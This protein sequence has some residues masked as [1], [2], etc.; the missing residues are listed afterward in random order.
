MLIQNLISLK[1]NPD[2]AREVI[3][4]LNNLKYED[5]EKIKITP[6]CLDYD[7]IK[8]LISKVKDKKELGKVALFFWY[9]YE[10]R[11]QVGDVEEHKR[12]VTKMIDDLLSAIETM[13][14]Q[15]G[16]RIEKSTFEVELLS[17]ATAMLM[18]EGKSNR[19]NYKDINVDNLN[20]EV[21]REITRCEDRIGG[22]G[23]SYFERNPNPVIHLLLK[24]QEDKEKARQRA[25][26]LAHEAI[27]VL[28][29]T[30]LNLTAK[31]ESQKAGKMAYRTR[32]IILLLYTLMLHK[33]SILK[34]N[35]DLDRK[36]IEKNFETKDA[37][38]IIV[39]KASESRNRFPSEFEEEIPSS[40]LKE[41]LTML[42]KEKVTLMANEII[43]AGEGIGGF[44]IKV[45]GK[46]LEYIL[47]HDLANVKDMKFSKESFSKDGPVRRLK[48]ALIKKLKKINNIESDEESDEESDDESDGKKKDKQTGSS[49]TNKFVLAVPLTCL[50]GLAFYFWKKSRKE[51]K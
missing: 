19:I 44:E 16:A 37:Y 40:L 3:D 9:E 42:G 35:D 46:L 27:K 20:I 50:A 47:E 33:K 8:S 10:K 28:H 13:P 39:N 29:N 17:I 41:L 24:A 1:S 51:E 14:Y 30:N 12:T 38:K 36:I 21:A 6:E 5:L 22:V 31:V 43:T 45:R 7:I 26:M 23:Q 11:M 48:P 18:T 2:K 49:L 34:A 32:L 25:I 15:P 4:S